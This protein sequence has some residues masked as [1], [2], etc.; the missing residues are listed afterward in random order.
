MNT[1]FILMAEF[2]ARAVIPIDE[3][4]KSYFSHLE[5]DKLL[6][7]I[8]LGE[9]ALPLVRIEKSAKS[10]KGVYLMD[11][12]NYI[13]QRRAEAQ[14]EFEQMHG[15]K[16]SLSYVATES[17]GCLNSNGGGQRAVEAQ[18]KQ[19]EERKVRAIRIKEVL[20]KV[21]LGESTLYR[22]I[23]DGRFPKPFEI[24]PKRNAWIESDIDD[25]IAERAGKKVT[26]AEPTQLE[27]ND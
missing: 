16:Q 25:W 5:L 9:I 24:V 3:V 15:R 17:E 20:A 10:A 19:P 26:R 18:E 7:K 21:G 12:A 23:A 22:M 27:S 1:V 14:K 8:S 13:D 11:L 4:R 6:R 2:G